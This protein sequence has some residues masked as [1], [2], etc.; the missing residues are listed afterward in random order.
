MTNLDSVL[1]SKNIILLTKVCIVKVMVF[2]VVI[3]GCDSWTIKKAG[4][5]QIDAIK[6]RCWRRL[7]NIPWTARRS[8]Q[9]ILK[10]VNPEYSLEGLM[11]L[12]P[13]DAKSWLIR[14]D[15]HAEKEGRQEEKGMTGRD[16]WTTSLTQRTQVWAI[17]GKWWRI[18]KS[19]MLQP[20]ESK[21]SDTTEQLNNNKNN[22]PTLLVTTHYC[23]PKV[24]LPRT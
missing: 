22:T 6:L 15:A 11:I 10:E 18:G 9:S 14:K 20:T 16:G 4:C 23:H 13:A 17:S 5:R 1:K 21:E 8:N 12:Y 24:F 7:L 19:G 3:Y 2:P